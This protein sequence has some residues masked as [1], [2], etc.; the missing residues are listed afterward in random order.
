VAAI[1]SVAAVVAY[2][3]GANTQWFGGIVAFGLIAAGVGLVGWARNAMPDEPA[4]GEREP[5][6]SSE[7]E[8]RAFVEAFVHGEESITR[9]RLLTGSL[10]AIGGALGAT[11]L[12]MLRA[13]GP[14]P[15][16]ILEHTSWSKGVRVVTEDGK[17]VKPGDL[18]TGGVL[19]VF[20]EG[21]VDDA[22]AQTLLIRVGANQLALP[23]DRRSWVVQNVVAYSKICTHAA[24]PVGL[25]QEHQHLLLCPCHQ[26]TFD[27][28][29]GAR[30]TSGP[31]ARS[32][33]QL[34]LALDNDGY[35]VAQSDYTTPVGPG[36]WRH[37]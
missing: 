30:P 13:L 26:S 10:L 1:C 12:S 9:R 4:V 5:L 14:D 29:D 3:A 15:G 28:L 19:T 34:P 22:S 2:W 6:E 20:P 27:V 7:E 17:P 36:F 16:P 31:A 8:R 35:L 21:H 37:V 18:F 11:V 24:C 33:P 32:L 23:A 25:Y